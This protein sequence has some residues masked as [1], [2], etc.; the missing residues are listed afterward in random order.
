M[1]HQ[2]LIE[3]VIIKTFK[4]YHIPLDI[5]D[6]IRDSFRV[7]LWRMGKLLSK[8]GTKSRQAQLAK[9]KEGDDNMWKFTVTESEIKDQIL[10]RKCSLKDFEEEKSKRLCLERKLEEYE[11]TILQQSCTIN[12]QSHTINQQSCIINRSGVQV[13][14][15]MRTSL[16]ECS[17]QQ[18]YNRKKQMVEG[19]HDSLIYLFKMMDMTCVL[20]K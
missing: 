20:L 11:T 3:R 12:K 19:I 9:R 2:L 7:K 15:A 10:C 18:K 1:P 14:S 6:T 17:R 4:H 5:S 8:Q 16:T 13:R